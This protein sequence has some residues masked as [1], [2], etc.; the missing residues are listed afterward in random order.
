MTTV[1]VALVRGLKERGV[2]VVFGIPG[3]HTIE[4]YRGLPGSG[5]RHV[6]ARHEGA[7]GFM[8]D[9][10]ARVSGKPGVVFVITGPGVTNMLTPMG[11]ARGE[12]IPLLVIS[13]VNARATLGLGLGYLHEMPDQR[14][15]MAALALHSEQ[16]ATAGALAPALDRAFAR[17]TTRRGG[18]VHLEV[19]TDVMPAPCPVRVAPAALPRAPVPGRAAL[20]QAADLLAGAS[21]PLILAGGGARHAEAA[22]QALARRLDAPVVQTVNAR[23]LMHGDPLIVPASPSMEAVR[24]LI[25]EADAVLAVGTELGPTDYDMYGRLGLPALPRL[26]RIDIDANQLARHPALIALQ[27]DA[28]ATLAALLPL[29]PQSTGARGAERAAQTLSAAFAEL[30]KPMQRQIA[31]LAKLRDALPRAIFVGDS[32][33]LV[34]AGNLFHDHD[35]PGGW[36]NSATGFGSLGFGVPA[37]IGAAIAAP[38]AAVV[39]LTGDGG[40]Q[41]HLADLMT[42]R[43]ENLDIT[44]VVWNNHGYR[45]IAD[46]MR[47]AGIPV[48]GCDPSP[49][50]LE[51]L[52][53][54]C[55]LPFASVV[56]TPV[57]LAG[58]LQRMRAVAGP[59][60]IEIRAD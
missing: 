9:G 60:M 15:L 57:A 42:A 55:S 25:A 40:L 5:I 46:N 10:Y 17:M 43:D 14:G 24:A 56:S 31:L 13:G 48:T 22:L 23:G 28:A 41:F 52:A 26:I 32:T 6:T 1:G 12:S 36:F 53:A 16:I 50:L 37:A 38:D 27:G 7:A 19:P 4:L 44:F 35:R 11:Q 20:Q 47:D 30:T 34:Y 49:P 33:Q 21:R 29:V 51:P 8:A 3:A 58:A 45:E 2:E 59:K 39:C 18:P 54:A